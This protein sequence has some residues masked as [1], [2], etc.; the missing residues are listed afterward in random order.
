[1]TAGPPAILALEDGTVFRGTGFGAR[2][3]RAG[4][5]VFN[6]SLSGYQ[7]VLSDPSYRGQIVTMTSPLIGNYGVTPEDMESHRLWLSGFVVR[8]RSRVVSNYR[9]TGT[10][11]AL[12]E[13]HNVPGIEGVDTRALT[14]RIRIEGA[15]RSVLSTGDEQDADDLVDRARTA[16][17]MAG[18]DLASEVTCSEISEWTEGPDPA[19]ALDRLEPRPRDLLVVAVDFGAK[20]NILRSLVAAGFRV[21]RVPA[22]TKA[23]EILALEPDGV[24]LSNGPGD[25]EPV[26]YA[27]EAVRGLLGKKPIFGI[28]LGHQILGLALGLPTFKLKFGHHGSNQPVKDLTTGRIEITAQN[29]GFA[30]D[31]SADQSEG[32]GVELTHVNLNDNTVEGFRHRDLSVLSVQHHPEASPGPH[33]SQHLFERFREMIERF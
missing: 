4:E 19:L 32:R 9:A 18:R 23:E 15:M 7:E 29:H 28:C 27:Q 30:V 25:P 31:L 13:E 11:D 5:V 3:V 6:T 26:T 17:P 33:D 12:L 1:V 8:E 21:T 20:W 2:T 14:R 22:T 10:L 24:F 16:P